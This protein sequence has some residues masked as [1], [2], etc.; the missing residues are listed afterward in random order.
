MSAEPVR[1]PIETSIAPPAPAAIDL[2]TAALHFKVSHAFKIFD[3]DNS[4][5]VDARCV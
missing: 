2:E 5:Q 1:G 4:N 3:Q